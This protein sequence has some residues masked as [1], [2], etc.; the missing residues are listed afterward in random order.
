MART[1]VITSGKGG[2]GK[3]SICV[4]L[5]HALASLNL[6]VLLIDIDLGL[7]NLDVVILTPQALKLKLG[8]FDNFKQNIIN[9]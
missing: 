5:G 9:T 7:N 2:V 4:N 3:T 6:K 8:S 1:I